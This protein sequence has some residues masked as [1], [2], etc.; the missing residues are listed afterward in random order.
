MV[1]KGLWYSLVSH[2]FKALK[3]VEE[4]KRRDFSSSL[5]F[6]LLK[7]YLPQIPMCMSLASGG[8][9]EVW[10]RWYLSLVTMP[11]QIK[12]GVLFLRNTKEGQA[13]KRNYHDVRLA[14]VEVSTLSIFTNVSSSFHLV[15][16]SCL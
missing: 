5:V 4:E 12:L 8:Y 13:T 11:P 9:K 1:A 6:F 16:H 10:R 7:R 15:D 3:E 14:D 2:V